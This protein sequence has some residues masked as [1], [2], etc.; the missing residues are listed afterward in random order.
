MQIV[1]IGKE[2][3]DVGTSGWNLHTGTGDRNFDRVVAFQS[4]LTSTPIVQV[5][6]AWLDADGAHNTRVDVLAVNI[7]PLGFTL[8]F[9]TYADTKLFGVRAN[10]F[11][12]TP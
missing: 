5:N 8:R 6:L 9:H 2:S 4:A 10:W 3:G 12:L 11:A 1:L 7:T